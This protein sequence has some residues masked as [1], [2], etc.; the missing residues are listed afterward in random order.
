MFFKC[1]YKWGY[2]K[3]NYELAYAAFD[4]KL[5]G[6]SHPL[7]PAIAYTMPHAICLAALKAAQEMNED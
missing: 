6:D 2:E 3:D 1:N 4:W 5:T 7:Y